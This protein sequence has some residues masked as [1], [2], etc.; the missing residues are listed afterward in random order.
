VVLVD[1]P[2]A[3]LHVFLQDSIF[4]ELGKAAAEMNS[5]L[6][7][8]THSEV[9]FNSAA[10]E[11]ICVMMGKPHRLATGK[12]VDNLRQAVAVLQQSDLVQAVEAPGILYLEG[13]TDLNLLRE[14]ARILGHPLADYLSRTPFWRGKQPPLRPDAREVPA[15]AHFDALKLVNQAITGIWFI[16]ADGRQIPPSERPER[17]K[18]NRLCWSRYEAESYLVHPAA[19]ARFIDRKAGAGGAEAVRRFL[20][21][22]FEGYAGTGLGA[23]IADAFIQNPLQ[24]SRI[25]E[26]YLR[27][28]KA[29]KTIVGGV[30][31][32]GGLHGMDYTRFS[33]IAAIMEPQ[34]IHPE[35]KEKLDFIQQAFGL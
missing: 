24:P 25:V 9:I 2:D 13:Y 1:E 8:A 16:D 35:V 22:A 7:I 31:Q 29:R 20:A 19:L 15:S 11:Q 33:E 12:E 30:L 3:H 34:E 26:N 14:W 32:E 18:L 21:Q 17:G 28:T 27:E 23:P 6:I 5:Q 10:P 4:A